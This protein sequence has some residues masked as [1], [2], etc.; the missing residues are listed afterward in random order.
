MAL[1]MPIDDYDVY[2]AGPWATKKEYE[3]KH[4]E[5]T[6]SIGESIRGRLGR[7]IWD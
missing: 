4:R 6:K 2:Y 5:L 1:N 3:T 7:N